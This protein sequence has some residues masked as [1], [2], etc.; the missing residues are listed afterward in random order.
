MLLSLKG[1]LGY[2]GGKNILMINWLKHR[3]VT[4]LKSFISL[5]YKI[6]RIKMVNIISFFHWN[7]VRSCVYVFIRDIL[8]YIRQLSSWEEIFVDM[9]NNKDRNN[10]QKIRKRRDVTWIVSRQHLVSKSG[11][12][13]SWSLSYSAS[14]TGMHFHMTEIQ[15]A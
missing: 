6:S 3:N 13:S 15:R 7:Y 4:L 8:L 11:W 2:F 9:G 12:K 5:N 1:I 14:L 10:F